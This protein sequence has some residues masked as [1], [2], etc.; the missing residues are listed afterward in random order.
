MISCTLLSM[1]SWFSIT[2][3]AQNSGLFLAEF[4]TGHQDTAAIMAKINRSFDLE[5]TQPDSAFILLREALDKS[6]RQAYPDGAGMALFGLGLM[7]SELNKNDTALQLYRKALPYLTSSVRY[8]HMA[9]ATYSN[10]GYIFYFRGDYTG[11]ISYYDSAVQAGRNSNRPQAK[12]YTAITLNSIAA[13]HMRLGRKKLSL[14]YLQQAEQLCRRYNFTG[15]LAI[16][17]GNMGELCT[18]LEQYDSADRYY[19]LALQLRPVHNSMEAAAGKASLLSGYANLRMKEGKPQEA[20][21]L[22]QEAAQI[23]SR[24]RSETTEVLPS[25]TMGAAYLQL[26]AYPQA[27]R[28]LLKALHAAIALN[29]N[30]NRDDIHEALSYVYE[31]TGRY[32]ESLH[33]YRL[34]EQLKDSLLG[35]EKARDIGEIDTRYRTAEKDRD[36]ARK[37][38]QISRQ[39][40]RLSRQQSWMAGIS[41]G[42]LLLGLLFIARHRLNRQ[43][44]KNQ[45]RQ[46]HI[47]EQ[48]QALQLQ[49]QEIN[50][51]NDIVQGEEKERVRIARELH[52]GIISQL[53][54][55]RLHFKGALQYA[56]GQLPN[57]RDFENTLQYLDDATREL[58]KTAHNLMPETVLQGGLIQA[59]YTYCDKMAAAAGIAIYVQHFGPD[60]PRDADLELS[61][62]RIVQE[63]VQ[64]AIKHAQCSQVLAELNIEGN[65]LS[66]DIEDNGCGIAPGAAEHS[67]GMGLKS[68]STRVKALGGTIEITGTPGRGTAVSMEFTLPYTTVAVDSISE[69]H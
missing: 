42:A 18:E 55:V 51:L 17:L 66:I 23:N 32:K 1:I 26:K 6:R 14:Q 36:I 54:G 53:M 3:T 7:Y 39:Q 33:H 47:L 59:L 9:Q 19:H 44:Q 46:I 43:K 41:A 4:A 37:Q 60:M 16:V 65:L 31:A 25:Y 58:R 50:H 30:D 49:Q 40:N 22:L 12:K 10:M 69:I 45:A 35:K 15:E 57:R 27:E 67:A 63:L 13:I 29:V 68:I 62:Y 52:D 20:I 28:Y 21:R 56:E 11:A 5:N 48:Q 34:Y 61:L 64:N 38:L 8:R 2:A 24:Y